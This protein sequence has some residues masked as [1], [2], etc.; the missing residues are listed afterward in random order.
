METLNLR[1]FR[2]LICRG[3][4]AF[5]SRSYRLSRPVFGRRRVAAHPGKRCTRGLFTDIFSVN[6]I[7]YRSQKLGFNPDN[8]K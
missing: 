2:E 1:C 7:N 4:R 5:C 3:G 6:G 8:Y